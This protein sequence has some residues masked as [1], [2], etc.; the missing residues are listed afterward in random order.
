VNVPTWF[1]PGNSTLADELQYNDYK[2][3]SYHL[4]GMLDTDDPDDRHNE[5]TLKD[6]Y[7]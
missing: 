2:P 5:W 7:D 4:D 3:D 1:Y 6:I